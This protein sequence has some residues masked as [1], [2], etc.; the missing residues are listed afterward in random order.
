[1]GI[2][3]GSNLV[4]RIHT[5]RMLSWTFSIPVHYFRCCKTYELYCCTRREKNNQQDQYVEPMLASC[6]DSVAEDG[7]TWSY[8]WLV[9][10]GYICLAKTAAIAFLKVQN[11]PTRA[12]IRARNLP[13]HTRAKANAS[14]K[15]R[16]K[17]FKT[18]FS[19]RVQANEVT[20]TI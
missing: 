18:V 7:L 14:A 10:T 12:R 5:G 1:M 3:I 16:E 19:W 11:T 4:Y 6:W 20:T 2:L 9:F 17:S 15:S 8:H 13:K